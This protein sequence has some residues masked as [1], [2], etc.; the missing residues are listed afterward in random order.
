MNAIIEQA[1]AWHVSS[2]N[3]KSSAIPDAWR[4][5]FREFEKKMGYRF[6]LRR[7]EYPKAV[8]AGGMMAVQSWWVNRGVAPVY[9]DYTLAF[10]IDG[11]VL[12]TGADLRKWLPG[13][14][15]FDGALYVPETIAP[16]AH[17]I[18][19]AILDPRTGRPAIRL[20]IQGRQSDGWYDLG[21][22]ETR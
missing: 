11:T 3:L 15:V 7:F 2:V 17:R 8:K 19:V 4:P 20:A 12:R 18:R 6:V 13:D 9:A 5:A 16:G 10:A 1:L 21:A 22:I 14:Q